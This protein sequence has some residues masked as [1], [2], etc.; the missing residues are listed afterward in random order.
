M[1]LKTISFKHILKGFMSN[2]GS[3][4]GLAL[5]RWQA[6][7]W[8]NDDPI[9]KCTSASPGLKELKRVTLHGTRHPGS[10][11]NNNHTNTLS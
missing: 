10:H 6:I 4:N 2:T 1:Y 11:V 3:G 8:T 9:H 7:T 5:N